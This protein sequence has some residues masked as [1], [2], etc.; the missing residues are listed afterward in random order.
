MEDNR[1]ILHMLNPAPS[2]IPAD[3]AMS[4]NELPSLAG[5]REFLAWHAQQQKLHAQQKM[6]QAKSRSLK[7]QP[8]ANTRR[9]SRMTL[10]DVERFA[11][12]IGDPQPS[13]LPL[14]ATEP[15]PDKNAEEQNK[16]R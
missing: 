15:A 7:R 8:S 5:E 14:T 6:E 12:G 4:D 1:L 16:N 2:V 13:P 3:T 9:K 10:A 11:Q